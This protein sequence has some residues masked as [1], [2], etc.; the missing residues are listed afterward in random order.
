MEQKQNNRLDCS[1]GRTVWR[2]AFYLEIQKT[3]DQ[4]LE[5]AK[6]I[7]TSPIYKIQKMASKFEISTFKL[8]VLFLPVGHPEIYPIEMVWGVIKRN[9][10]EAN[11]NFNLTEVERIAR[12]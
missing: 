3:M 8:K 1:M 12:S 2:L 9:M 5:E 11:V 6:R 7:Y 10:A 4:L